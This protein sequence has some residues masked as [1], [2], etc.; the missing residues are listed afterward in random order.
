MRII[1]GTQAGIP[2]QTPR[3][4]GVRPTVDRVREAIFNRL[5]GWIP[6][7]RVLDLFSGTG[8]MGLESVSRGAAYVESVELSAKH[9]SYIKKNVSA[10]GYGPTQIRL[11]QNCAFKA[12][13]ELANQSQTFDLILAD[14]PFGERTRQ[15]RS[16]SAAQ[17]LLDDPNL[18]KI[19]HPETRIVL[20]HATRD[21]VQIPSIW[22]LEK[23]QRYGDATINY[24]TPNPI[25]DTS[26]E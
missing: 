8:A 22:N 3:G 10:C 4:Q 20:G 23:Q 24:L 26:T 19:C 15:R 13:A 17:K 21:Q 5:A 18:P 11:R 25:E 14:P 16:E 6:G 7:T 2:I 9:L 1:G 12:I